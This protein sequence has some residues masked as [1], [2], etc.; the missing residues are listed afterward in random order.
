MGGAMTI[1]KGFLSLMAGV[2]VGITGISAVSQGKVASS[3]IGA[4]AK[5]ANVKGKV[6]IFVVMPEIAAL[7]GFV[8]A[9][10]LL[11]TGQVF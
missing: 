1:E 7:F 9:I 3:S 2:A 6:L 4:T 5:N 8:T 11:I 10:M